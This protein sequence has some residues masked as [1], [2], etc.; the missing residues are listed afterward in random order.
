MTSAESLVFATEIGKLGWA[1]GI[2]WWD[3]LYYFRIFGCRD[4]RPEFSEI[5]SDIWNSIPNTWS[6]FSG[7]RYTGSG[8]GYSGSGF[9]FYARSDFGALKERHLPGN[10][11]PNENEN[12]NEIWSDCVLTVVSRLINTH[13]QALGTKES[14]RACDFSSSVQFCKKGSNNKEFLVLEDDQNGRAVI[15]ASPLANSL[16]HQTPHG[17]RGWKCLL[18]GTTRYS[19]M[20]RVK[21]NLSEAW[22][23]VYVG[24]INNKNHCWSYW[25]WH[26][27]LGSSYNIYIL[28]DFSIN[29]LKLKRSMT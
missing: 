22:K 25:Y 16:L 20:L 10:H 4:Y 7:S 23:Y 18:S 12:P 8:S 19:E 28:T 9:G 29:Q 11:G 24:A 21:W 26:D 2:S 15:L 3:G 27:L 13:C 17:E 6:G 14:C 5:Y 1:S